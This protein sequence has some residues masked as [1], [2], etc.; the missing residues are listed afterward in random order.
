MLEYETELYSKKQRQINRKSFIWKGQYAH[1]H[2]NLS[3]GLVYGKL[4]GD[5][6]SGFGGTCLFYWGVK[7]VCYIPLKTATVEGSQPEPRR[8]TVCALEGRARGMELV[9]PFGAQ[10][11]MRIPDAQH[12]TFYTVRLGFYFDLSINVT[13]LFPIGIRKYLTCVLIS[14]ELPS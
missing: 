12:W 6:W 10:K 7:T 8:Q 3:V 13:W 14:R 11:I 1:R 2:V 9:R 5:I 4:H